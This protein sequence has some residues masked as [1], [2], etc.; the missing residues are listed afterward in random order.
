MRFGTVV[1]AAIGLLANTVSAGTDAEASDDFI[2]QLNEQAIQNLNTTETAKRSCNLFTAG[3]R[4][5][6]YVEN[7]TAA[8]SDP[9]AYTLPL[10]DLSQRKGAQGVHQRCSMPPHQAL[11]D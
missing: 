11:Q 4:K 7:Y 8:W 1:T 5:D 6:W 3:V 2:N 10:Q 9:L